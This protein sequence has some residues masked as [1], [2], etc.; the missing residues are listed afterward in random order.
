MPGQTASQLVHQTSQFHA[1]VG[2]IPLIRVFNFDITFAV[3]EAFLSDLEEIPS[4]KIGDYVFHLEVNDM[5]PEVKEIARKEL[6]ETPDVR[7]EAVIALRDLLRGK[8]CFHLADPGVSFWD[9]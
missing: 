1:T 5:T 3:K 4:L 6:R 2:F 7:K 8:E 9:I